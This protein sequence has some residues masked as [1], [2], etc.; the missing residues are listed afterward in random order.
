MKYRIL[1]DQDRL[2]GIEQNK[3]GQRSEGGVIPV[4]TT[5]QTAAHLK[6]TRRQIYRYVKR[7]ALHP[8]GPFLGDWLFEKRE[9]LF[10]KRLLRKLKGRFNMPET[11][12]PLFPEYRLRDLNWSQD[13]NL[14]LARILEK[15]TRVDHK[16]IFKVYPAGRIRLFL[17]E[18][19]FRELSSKS[20]NFWCWWLKVSP[21]KLNRGSLLGQ[22]LGGVA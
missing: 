21:P 17:R 22:R 18:S 2:I 12:K 20:L 13:A 11:W 5:A 15:G 8:Y 9:V 4:L 10:L 16:I 7:K 19:A 3:G 14:I 1:F 6:R